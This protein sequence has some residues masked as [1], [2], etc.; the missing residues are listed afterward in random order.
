MILRECEAR[1]RMTVSTS[2]SDSTSRRR[3]PAPYLAGDSAQA[4]HHITTTPPALGT[5]CSGRLSAQ[6]ECYMPYARLPSVRLC[7]WWWRASSSNALAAPSRRDKT[8][9]LVRTPGCRRHGRWAS[10]RC[11]APTSM[12][13]TPTRHG[14]MSVPTRMM[15]EDSIIVL[16]DRYRPKPIRCPQPWR[17]A[18]G[19]VGVALCDRLSRR[20]LDGLY[21]CL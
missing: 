4:V 6:P 16:R 12:R 17:Q 2:I 21:S 10:I 15:V 3:S 1:V 19:P 8:A 5:T 7:A 14:D 9:D 11:S 18:A 20:H 13:V